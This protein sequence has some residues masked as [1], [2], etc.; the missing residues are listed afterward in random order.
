MGHIAINVLRREIYLYFP[1]AICM[2]G[3]NI[4]ELCYLSCVDKE[5]VFDN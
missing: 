4:K 3:G 5:F 2:L 1:Q